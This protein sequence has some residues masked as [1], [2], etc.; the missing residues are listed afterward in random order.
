LTTTKSATGKST[1]CE[2]TGIA[3]GIYDITA[4]GQSTLMNV[5]KGV[6]ITAPQMSV[7]LGILLESDVNQDNIVNFDDY[8][9]LTICWLSSKDQVVYNVGVDFRLER[10]N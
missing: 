7:D 10:P 3:P 6:V 2:A 1:I 9:A 8:T 5:K 4:L